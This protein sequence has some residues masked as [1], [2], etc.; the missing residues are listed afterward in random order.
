MHWST[1]LS[2]LLGSTIPAV[3]GSVVMLHLKQR[4][5]QSLEYLKRDFQQHLT[6]FTKWHEKR[7]VA[8]EAIYQAFCKYLDFLRRRLY[9]KDGNESLDPMHDFRKTLE[10]Q[11]LYLDDSM[12]QKISQYQGELLLF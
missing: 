9:V 12:A 11:M 7:I 4:I 10:Q 1:V 8:L 5:D 6:K 2:A 3:I